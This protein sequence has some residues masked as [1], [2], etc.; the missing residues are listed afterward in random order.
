M[1]IVAC[2][3]NYIFPENLPATT[4]VVIADGFFSHSAISGLKDSEMPE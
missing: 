4:D 3:S 2:C 1:G